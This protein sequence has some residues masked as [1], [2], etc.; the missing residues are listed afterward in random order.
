MNPYP[1]GSSQVT[2]AFSS[3]YERHSMQETLRPYL[4]GPVARGRFILGTFAP[5]YS[6]VSV[7]T[8]AL[9][10]IAE[11]IDQRGLELMARLLNGERSSVNDLAM[12]SNAVV[13]LSNFMA[14]REETAEY[15]AILK[16]REVLG[17]VNQQQLAHT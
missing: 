12:V 8:D 4:S 14:I 1:K 5:R 2:F 13:A 17:V 11:G 15:E 7:P 3:P 9:P 6:D 16:A 10:A